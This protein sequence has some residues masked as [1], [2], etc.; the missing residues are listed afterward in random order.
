MPANA[1]IQN[2]LKILD[3]GF[4]RDDGKSE[5]RT[6]YGAVNLALNDSGSCDIGSFSRPSHTVGETLQS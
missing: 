4:R 2:L 6:F 1:G 5:F 3:P